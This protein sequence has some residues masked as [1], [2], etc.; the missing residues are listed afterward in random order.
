MN[1]LYKNY[2]A[3]K[4]AEKAFFICPRLSEG[5]SLQHIY[6]VQTGD[7][8]KKNFFSNMWAN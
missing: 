4:T 6:S 5:Q 2:K 7:T 8:S 3:D 1:K